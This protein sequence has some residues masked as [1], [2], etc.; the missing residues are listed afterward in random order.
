MKAARTPQLERAAIIKENVKFTEEGLTFKERTSAL[1]GSFSPSFGRLVESALDDWEET[2]P[3]MRALFQHAE[4][5]KQMSPNKFEELA[6]RI[7]QIPSTHAIVKV[8]PIRE[9]ILTKSGLTPRQRE[10]AQLM[11]ETSLSY[12]EI[13]RRLSISEGTLRKHVE[14]IYRQINVRSRAELIMYL[15]ASKKMDAAEE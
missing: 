15:H 11:A 9:D 5:S 12:K 10:I 14:N 7:V 13:A 2:T 8:R 1:S 3:E 4:R 6:A